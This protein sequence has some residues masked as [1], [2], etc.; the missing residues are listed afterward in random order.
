MKKTIFLFLLMLGVAFA[1]AQTK[2]AGHTYRNANVM[3]SMMDKMMRDTEA[4]VRENVNT[5]I[6]AAEKKKGRKLTAEERKELMEKAVA[7]S[8]AMIA[9]LMKTALTI[10]FKDEK[11]LTINMDVTVNEEAMKQLGINW[12]KRKELKTLVSVVPSFNGEYIVKDHL[13]IVY[14]DKQPS[15]TLRVSPDGK[16]L[17]GKMDGINYTLTRT[18]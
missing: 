17:Y 10:D 2:L 9:N 11:K 14:E 8:K 1:N 12:L 15:D 7:E 18:K 5:V 4:M 6:A 16:K 13:V 3:T